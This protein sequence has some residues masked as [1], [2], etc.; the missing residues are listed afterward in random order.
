MKKFIFNI[1]IIIF[2]TS[3]LIIGCG[4]NARQKPNTEIVINSRIDVFI[5][6]KFGEA[7]DQ[8]SMQRSFSINLPESTIIASTPSTKEEIKSHIETIEISFDTILYENVIRF[9]TLNP[10][11]RK[12]EFYLLWEKEEGN[13]SLFQELPETNTRIFFSPDSRCVH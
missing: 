8:E 5:D 4:M 6:K 12:N 9:R 10:N 13:Y 3:I 2:A 7:I 11:T 1:R